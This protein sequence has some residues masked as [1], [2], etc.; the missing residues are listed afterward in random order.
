MLFLIGFSCFGQINIKEVQTGAKY[1]GYGK[2][3]NNNIVF[4]GLENSIDS[5]KIYYKDIERPSEKILIEKT[6]SP[7]IGWLDNHTVLLL[8]KTSYFNYICLFD[9]NTNSVLSEIRDDSMIFSESNFTNDG[10]IL[11]YFPYY[12][13]DAELKSYKYNINTGEKTLI[14][15]LL[16]K[17]L[18][19]VAYNKKNDVL[20]FTWYD[21]E[22]KVSYL[23]V[24]NSG[25]LRKITEFKES[26]PSDESP[27]ILSDN[28]ETLYYICTENQTSKL[29]KYQLVSDRVTEVYEFNKGV[30]CLDLS[31][32][33]KRLLMTLDGMK[34]KRDLNVK[35]TDLKY[36]YNVGI[37]IGLGMYVIENL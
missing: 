9:I 37:E 3:K 21:R 36:E 23:S 17:E 20:A 19:R 18:E 7:P 33:D 26:N 13:E 29:Y 34:S 22:T 32:S 4:L 25:N 5:M 2:L 12:F 27:L 28:G 6:Y 31:Y 10:N 15:E 11:I 24:L 16:G 14:K 8:K 1:S 35:S 30:K